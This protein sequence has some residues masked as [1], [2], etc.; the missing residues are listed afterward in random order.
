[1]NHRPSAVAA[2]IVLSFLATAA[3]AQDDPYAA[4]AQLADDAARLS[5]FDAT[6]ANRQVAQAEEARAEEARREEVFGL[7]REDAGVVTEDVTV[8]AT[9]VEVLQDGSRRPVLVLDNG[10]IWREV[11]GSTLRNRVRDGWTATIGKHWSGVYEMRFEGRS[12]YLR[13]RRM[14]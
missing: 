4:C 14:Q 6:Y 1:M 5:C 2:A 11:G 12:G 7:R 10:Q 9:V 8:T 3:T 13:V